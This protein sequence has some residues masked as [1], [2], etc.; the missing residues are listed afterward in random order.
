MS[1][2]KLAPRMDFAACCRKALWLLCRKR[3]PP[4]IGFPPA[5]SACVCSKTNRGAKIAADYQLNCCFV[6][7]ML[8]MNQKECGVLT[9][10]VTD[11]TCKEDLTCPHRRKRRKP[12]TVEGVPAL[13]GR[14]CLASQRSPFWQNRSGN[15][16]ENDSRNWHEKLGSVWHWESRVCFFRASCSFR[17][18]H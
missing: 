10:A 6:F 2:N 9:W 16:A 18:N 8:I 3:I 4:G 12:G 17:K 5:V 14:V 13:R 1:S 15:A 7:S 11:S